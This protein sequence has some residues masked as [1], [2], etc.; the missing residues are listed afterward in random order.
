MDQRL[1]AADQPALD[2]RGDQKPTDEQQQLA[3]LHKPGEPQSLEEDRQFQYLQD[4]VAL[5]RELEKPPNPNLSAEI[6][7]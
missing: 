1:Q 6:Q 7:R 2:N 5:E 4:R 3:A